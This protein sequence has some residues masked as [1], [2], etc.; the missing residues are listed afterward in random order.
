MTIGVGPSLVSLFP[1]SAEALRPCNLEDPALTEKRC[2]H[3]VLC[4]QLQLADKG[5]PTWQGVGVRAISIMQ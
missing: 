5:Y 4:Q 2:T 1:Q 3:C